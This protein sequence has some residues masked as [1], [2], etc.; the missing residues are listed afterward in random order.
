MRVC[1]SEEGEEVTLSQHAV[2][3]YERSQALIRILIDSSLIVRK[4]GGG[5]VCVGTWGRGYLLWGLIYVCLCG[6]SA[7]VLQA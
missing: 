3:V 2:L 4:S 7:V 1:A 5:G 6:S